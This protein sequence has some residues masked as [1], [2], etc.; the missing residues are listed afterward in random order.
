MKLNAVRWG[1]AAFGLILLGATSAAC[2]SDPSTAEVS[3]AAA[4]VP[5]AG[6]VED[7]GLPESALEVM[8]QPQ[9]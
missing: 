8:S 6:A 7:A 3:R 4:S 1:G 9:Y 2:S 5:G